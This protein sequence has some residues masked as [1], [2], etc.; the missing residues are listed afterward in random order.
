MLLVLLFVLILFAFL[1]I[2]FFLYSYM[3][4]AVCGKRKK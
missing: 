3:D 4:E 1:F 2:G